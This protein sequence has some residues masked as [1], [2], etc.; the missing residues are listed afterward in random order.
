MELVEVACQKVFDCTATISNAARSVTSFSSM[1]IFSEMGILTPVTP[2]HLVVSEFRLCRAFDQ[3]FVG[4]ARPPQP[5]QEARQN[6]LAR[7]RDLR[8]GK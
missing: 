6:S 1:L 5:V 2:Q 8:R 4:R 7:L 3:G